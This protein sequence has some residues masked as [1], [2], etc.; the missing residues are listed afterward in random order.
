MLFV[1]LF[2]FTV[3]WNLCFAF[4]NLHKG[5]NGMYVLYF[6]LAAVMLASE[7]AAVQRLKGGE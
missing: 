7:R 3:V 4:I 6:I 1:W 5:N 2:R